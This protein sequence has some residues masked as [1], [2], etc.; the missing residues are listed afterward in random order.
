MNSPELI[1]A[2]VKLR[3]WELYRIT[4]YLLFRAFRIFLLPAAALLLIFLV[5]L[6]Y[7]AFHPSPENTVSRLFESFGASSY[8]FLGMLAFFLGIPLLSAW[9][10]YSNPRVREGTRYQLSKN[11]IEMETS[12][13]SANLAWAAFGRA[14]ETPNLFLLF[15]TKGMAYAIPKRSLAGEEETAS[16]RELLRNNVKKT[17]LRK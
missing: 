6:G 8:V 9:Q 15:V 4:A 2:H 16:V 17:K 10:T 14:I 1:R 12:V 11:G 13:G 5:F 3:F 7:I